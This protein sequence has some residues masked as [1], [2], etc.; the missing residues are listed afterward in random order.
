MH[1]DLER[2]RRIVVLTGAG[3]SV[4]SGLKPYRGPG[5]LWT[6]GGDATLAT[7]DCF[8][9]DPDASW[10]LFGPLRRAARD[11]SPNPAHEAL[12]ALEHRC[13][14]RVTVVTQNV[15]GL[16]QRAGSSDVIEI[17]GSVF[18]SRCADAACTQPV[19]DDDAYEGV[20]PRCPRCGVALRPD[21]VFFG[22][23]LPVDEEWAVKRALR[24]VDLFLAVG[25]SGTVSPASSYARSAAYN[26][27]RTIYVNLEPMD[28][29]NPYFQETH[30]GP[31]EDVLP[32][33][34]DR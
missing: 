12:A 29:P 4:A 34:L 26:E 14:G 32:A 13:E 5:G 9:A 6:E 27:A 21:V 8:H 20:V 15:D 7:L 10:A 2:Y 3:I 1:L 24:E 28:P 23:A 16:H 11:A 17:H 31:A 33:I 18:R 22:E 19:V 30:L 25:T